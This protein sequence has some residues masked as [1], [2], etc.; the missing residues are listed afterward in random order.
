MTRGLGTGA[1]GRSSPHRQPAGP[2]V[3]AMAY[4]PASQQ[5]VLFGGSGGSYLGTRGLERL[6]WAQLSPPPALRPLRADHGLRPRHIV[7]VLFGGFTG[8]ARAIRGPGT[9]LVQALPATPLRRYYSTMA[10]DPATARWSSSGQPQ[11]QH[12]HER[13]LVDRCSSV[14]AVSPA[15][16][17]RRW[18]LG[19]RHRRGVQRRERISFGS[20]RPPSTWSIPPPRSP[21]PRR[22]VPWALSTS[23][24]H[25]RRSSSTSP[26]DKFAYEALPP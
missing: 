22:P 9:G 6:Q 21:S 2:G 7:P 16:A 4:D 10:Y 25:R 5:L 8:T 20:T 11:Q 15:S 17:C 24:S 3:A 23:S 14:T 18:Y 19:H 13:H 1:P 26:A 12:P